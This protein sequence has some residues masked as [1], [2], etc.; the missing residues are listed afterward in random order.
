MA[1]ET[2]TNKR[3]ASRDRAC[4]WQHAPT[5]LSEASDILVTVGIRNRSTLGTLDASQ[6]EA[7]RRLH[8]SHSLNG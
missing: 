2:A 1:T 6:T 8:Q 4:S 7:D 3:L 5:T